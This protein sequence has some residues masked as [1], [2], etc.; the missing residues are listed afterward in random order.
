MNLR[1]K[2]SYQK[3]PKNFFGVHPVFPRL[4]V[5]DSVHS[6]CIGKTLSQLNCTKSVHNVSKILHPIKCHTVPHRHFWKNRLLSQKD[7]QVFQA[8]LV[9][10]QIHCWNLRRTSYHQDVIL[11][12]LPG[13]SLFLEGWWPSS[14]VKI[15]SCGRS[16]VHTNKR[17]TIFCE[18]FATGLE[19]R[20]GKFKTEKSEIK[21]LN[22]G[23]C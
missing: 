6:Y 3:L 10:H 20:E 21:D 13:S 14:E 17:T 5:G 16:A 18:S 1:S 8:Q 9:A 19:W 7:Y 12:P 23:W 15:P 22:S 11:T 2:N 4:S